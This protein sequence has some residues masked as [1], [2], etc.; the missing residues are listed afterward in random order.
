MYSFLESHSLVDENQFGF[1]A[2]HSI[3]DAVAKLTEHFRET[4]SKLEVTSLLL[5]I[6]KAFD[7][8]DHGILLWKL[9][10]YQM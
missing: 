3:I 10:G 1:R 5:D 8:I 4:K 7:T 6:T 2:K 9:D